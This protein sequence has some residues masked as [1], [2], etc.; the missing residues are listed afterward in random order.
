GRDGVAPQRSIGAPAGVR[1]L[2]PAA[3]R[4]FHHRAVVAA[5]PPYAAG[6]AQDH[7]LLPGRR[8]A[9][10]A[11]VGDHD[12]SPWASGSS[13]MASHHRRAVGA[14]PGPPAITRGTPARTAPTDTAPTMPRRSATGPPPARKSVSGWPPADWRPTGCRAPT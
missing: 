4:R 7:S 9:R 10:L 2:D 8:R 6:P 12:A 5:H 14:P 3:Q 13:R 1:L 11:G